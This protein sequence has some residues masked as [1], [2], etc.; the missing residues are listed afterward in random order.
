MKKL[1]Y[2]PHIIF[3][4]ALAYFALLAFVLEKDPMMNKMIMVMVCGLWLLWI[5]AKTFIKTLMVLALLA[6]MGYAGY[7]ITHAK[8]IE[9]KNAGRE[10]NAKEQICEDKKTISEKLKNAVSNAVKSTLKK[11]KEEKA[12]AE[13]QLEEKA[14]EVNEAQ[15]AEAENKEDTEGKSE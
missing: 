5:F 10:W 13:E 8:E 7:Y 3:V 15:T 4:V 2:I 6:A 1:K 11:L 9:C 14:K 12:K